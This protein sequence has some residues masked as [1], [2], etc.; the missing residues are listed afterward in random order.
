[1]GIHPHKDVGSIPKMKNSDIVRLGFN[2]VDGIPAMVTNN[3]KVNAIR[4]Y[5]YKHDLDGFFGAETNINWK[6]MPDEGQLPELFHSED[7]IR[8]V[9][10]FNRFENWGRRQQGGT[11]GLVLDNWLL[12]SE[13]LAVMTS[14]NGLGCFSR[15]TQ[16]TRCGS[17]RHINL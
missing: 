13:M 14:V 11:F 1:V 6:K 8:T 3:S 10:S 2:N 15:G 5:A 17:L 4:R 16:G 12:R 9:S 7:A